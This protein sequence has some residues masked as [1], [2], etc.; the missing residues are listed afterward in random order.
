MKCSRCGAFFFASTVEYIHNSLFS[1]RNKAMVI[2][3]KNSAV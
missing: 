3:L 2:Q 1:V